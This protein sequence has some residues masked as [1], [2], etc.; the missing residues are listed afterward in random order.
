MQQFDDL[1][2]AVGR[3]KR[4]I[5]QETEYLLGFAAA[6]SFSDASSRN[7]SRLKIFLVVRVGEVLLKGP[8]ACAAQRGLS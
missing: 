1:T 5:M 2:A 4:R 3:V 6:P 7:S 8:A